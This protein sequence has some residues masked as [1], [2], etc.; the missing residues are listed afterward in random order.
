MKCGTKYLL[1]Y[2]DSDR[3]VQFG[4]IVTKE[5]GMHGVDGG[6]RVCSVKMTQNVIVNNLYFIYVLVD[7][8]MMF[9]LCGLVNVCLLLQLL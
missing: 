3:S 4:L 9:C 2:G 1:F 6:A 5:F 7:A 8:V